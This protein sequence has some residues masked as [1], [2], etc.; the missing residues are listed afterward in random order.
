MNGRGMKELVTRSKVNS[1]HVNDFQ[2]SSPAACPPPP[3]DPKFAGPSI[4]A[5]EESRL[6]E[7]YAISP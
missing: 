4:R 6:S 5:T 7:D 3:I 1:K 2:E